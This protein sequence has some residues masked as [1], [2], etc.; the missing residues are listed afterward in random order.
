MRE[1]NSGVVNKIPS[2]LEKI[3]FKVF[4][5]FISTF[6]KTFKK[7]NIVRTVVASGSY[8]K[9]RLSPS[10]HDESCSALS[11]LYIECG[12]EKEKTSK[13]LLTQ[14]K[15]YQKGTRRLAVKER[16]QLGLAATE[17]NTPL[18]FSAYEYLEKLS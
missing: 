1:I 10:S 16:K 15:L 8:V 18:P 11:R 17:S 12:I 4:A 5:R 7:R 13:D 3:N 6:K 9:I 14:L 2:K